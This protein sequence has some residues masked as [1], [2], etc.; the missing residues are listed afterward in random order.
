VARALGVVFTALL[1]AAVAMAGTRYPGSMLLF[2]LFNLG[3]FFLLAL[4]FP[5]PR[6]YFYTFLAIFLTLGLWAKTLMHTLWSAGFLEP[7][8]NFGGTPAEWDAAL[9]AMSAAAFGLAAARCLHLVFRRRRP[10][11]EAAPT[12]PGWYA[13][14][15]TLVWVLTV[16]SMVAVNAANL[17]FAF[18]Q[19]G[20][21]P[22]LVLP[23]RLHVLFSWLVNIGFALWIAALIDWEFRRRPAGLAAALVAPLVE[24]VLSA[25]SAFSRITYL[26]HALPYAVALYEERRTLG[27]RQLLSLGAAFVVLFAT[28]VVMVFALRLHYYPM[29]D[30]TT[31]TQGDRGLVR[32]MARELPQLV[33]HR[34]V[35]LE[36]V[37][38]VG[39]VPSRGSEMLVAVI[40]DSP[41]HAAESIFQRASRLEAYRVDPKK[42]T[43]L[44]NAGPVAILLYSGSYTVVLLGMA[45]IATVAFATEEAA[46]RWTRNPFFVAVGAAALANVVSQTTYFYLTAIFLAQLWLAISL[47]ALVQGWRARRP[48]L[49]AG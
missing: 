19:I 32:N 10:L 17:H 46:R 27:R 40:A 8:G 14:H 44:T 29:V 20:V 12:V 4:V 33:L 21:N 45:L 41:K 42:F 38:T 25:A 36:G 34:W 26:I 5:P 39:S 23:L 18:F 13:Q 3:F 47:I 37:L 16:A 49:R 28:A 24:G 6:L 22:K 15:R 2:A 1:L 11:A 31:G 7:V 48:A 30:R 43:F 35:G 9:L